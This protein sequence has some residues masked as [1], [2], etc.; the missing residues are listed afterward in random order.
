MNTNRPK[1]TLDEARARIS[2]AKE[3]ITSLERELIAIA[4]PK[5]TITAAVAGPAFLGGST[6]TIKAPPIV[7]ILI[8]ETIYN[9]RTALDYLVYQLFYLDTGNLSSRTKFP[10]EDHK[11]SWNNYF[12]TAGTTAQERRKMWLY[13]LSAVHQAAIKGLQPCFGCNWT[14]KIRDLSNPDKHR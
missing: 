10:I 9:L 8:G 11:K 13:Q 14:A 6:Q 1:R 2:R 4:P 7:P 3:H 12:P 5:R